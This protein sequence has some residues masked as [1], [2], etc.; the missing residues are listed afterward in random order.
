MDLQIGAHDQ[1]QISESTWILLSGDSAMLPTD[2]EAARVSCDSFVWPDLM[3]ICGPI[4]REHVHET[5][6]LIAETLSP[7][8]HERNE[9]FKREL[10]CDLR[11][12]HDLIVDPE[13]NQIRWISHDNPGNTSDAVD[14]EVNRR[15]DRSEVSAGF[16]IKDR[17]LY[18]STF[19]KWKRSYGRAYEHNS[20]IPR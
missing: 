4:P 10:H 14:G 13:S 1:R 3:V 6:V 17:G 12:R 8:T 18:S 7:S 15:S 11:V 19:Y 2:A 20:W 9:T 16:L 5:P